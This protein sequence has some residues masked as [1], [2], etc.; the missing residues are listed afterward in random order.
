M[1]TTSPADLYYD[2][3]DFDI[4]SDPYPIFRRLREEQ[5]LYY[6][7]RYD[8]FALSRFDDVQAASVE[9]KTYISSKGTVL[10]ILKSDLE[11]P[12]GS[13]IFEDPPNHDLHRGL[14]SRV[15]T[16]DVSRLHPAHRRAVQNRRLKFGDKLN[17]HPH[18]RCY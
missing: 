18:R 15:F 4:D 10:E 12:P 3:Y 17:A 11:L 1:T 16:N 13:I 8:F 6:N 9:W 2:P 5:P 7:E 14:L